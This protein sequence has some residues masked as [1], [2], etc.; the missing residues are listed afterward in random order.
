MVMLYY[1]TEI[2]RVVKR[3]ASSLKSA[4]QVSEEFVLT[5]L[6]TSFYLFWQ[7]PNQG[8]GVLI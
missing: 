1:N 3:N 2:C 7:R 8:A 5:V 6:D 4:E